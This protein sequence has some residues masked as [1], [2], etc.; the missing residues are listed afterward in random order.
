MVFF[1]QGSTKGGMEG[2]TPVGEFNNH[3]IPSYVGGSPYPA[4][5]L[6]LVVCVIL[7]LEPFYH[8]CLVF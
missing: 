4:S 2:F 1:Y 6:P 8:F 5:V 7:L 3:N